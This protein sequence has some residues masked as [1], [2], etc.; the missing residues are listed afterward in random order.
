MSEDAVGSE[1]GHDV[2]LLLLHD[3]GDPLDELVERHTVHRPIF[4]AQ[5]LAP[6]RHPTERSPSRLIL[7]PPDGA[8]R[9]S[10]RRETFAMRA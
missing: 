3:A 8:E 6:V 4:V 5:P 1:R 2:G 7:G 9:L 10:G